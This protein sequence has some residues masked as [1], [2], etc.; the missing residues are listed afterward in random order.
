M[1]TVLFGLA[2]CLACL[3]ATQ[4]LEVVVPPSAAHPQDWLRPQIRDN[5][6]PGYQGKSAGS[7][8]EFV[9][10][11]VISKSSSINTPVP[12]TMSAA[13]SPPYPLPRRN[14]SGHRWNSARR[15]PIPTGPRRT[16]PGSPGPAHP[17][18]LSK[19]AGVAG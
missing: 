18:L 12:L 1:R 11:E 8:A 5:P 10:P 2:L 6:S 16:A 9:A 3:A 7:L 19:A 14:T 15:A 13:T 17:P 4:D